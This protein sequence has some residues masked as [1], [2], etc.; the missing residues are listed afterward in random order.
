MTEQQL[1]ML[2]WT[3]VTQYVGSRTGEIEVY[4]PTQDTVVAQYASE[5]FPPGASHWRR[6]SVSLAQFACGLMLDDEE[7]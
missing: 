2:G 6:K 1:E 7:V 4:I 5:P 3:P